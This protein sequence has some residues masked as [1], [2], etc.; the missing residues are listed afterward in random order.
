MEMNR[1]IRSKLVRQMS[2]KYW[3][4][5]LML[6]IVFFACNR[7]TQISQIQLKPTLE[8][9]TEDNSLFNPSTQSLLRTYSWL[10]DATNVDLSIT[11]EYRGTIDLMHEDS[12]HF[13]RI[14]NLKL[15]YLVPRLHYQ[16]ADPPD[17]FDALNLKLA[18][19]S[20]NSVSMPFGQHADKMTHYESNLSESVPWQL[21]GDFEFSPNRYYKPLRVSVVNNCLRP[22]LWELNA[23]DR[24]G[25][26]YHSWFDMPEDFYYKMAAEVNQLD[27]QFVKDATQWEEMSTKLELDRLRTE[28]ESFGKQ[29]VEL[30]DREIG[31]SSQGSRRK[32]SKKFVQFEDTDGAIRSPKKLSDIYLNPTY[33][34]SF[35]EPGIYSIEEKDRSEFDFTFL[36]NPQSAEVSLVEP[37]TNYNWLERA[38]RNAS[39]ESAYIELN[40]DLGNEEHLIVG[41][42][43]LELLVE[44]E[45]YV[46]HGFG[47][48]VLSPAGFA[49]RRNFLIADGPC[50]SYAYLAK[51][52]GGDYMGVNSHVR[53]VEQIY[54]RS[55]PENAVPYWD[56]I[57]TSYERIV[58]IVHYKIQIP[59]QLTRQQKEYNSQ[60]ISPIYFTYRDDNVN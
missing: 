44:Q 6:V 20:R 15:E 36:A 42:L 1:H 48:G 53:G 13:F 4:M 2:S 46:I 58:D 31:F 49:E 32:I 25:E 45:D 16:P 39:D 57:V 11:G 28:K 38:G 47:V 5:P 56:V 23:V 26:I 41:N 7:S 33:M 8:H 3:L 22:G 27:A 35:I 51:K 21:E 9:R 37:K 29:R 30:F 10:E 60:Y 17:A 40:I 14:A 50:P 19:Y 52:E 24:S 59:D 55:H 34:A 12:D 54:I 43:P 18:E